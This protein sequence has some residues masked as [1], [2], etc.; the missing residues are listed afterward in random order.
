M[1]IEV[2]T[3]SETPPVELVDK[4]SHVFEDVVQKEANGTC[5]LDPSCYDKWTDVQKSV[6][7][8]TLK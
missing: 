1:Y 5:Y 2:V 7:R 8:C 6:D 4:I 3:Q